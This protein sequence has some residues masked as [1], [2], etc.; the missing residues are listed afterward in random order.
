M[1]AHE[2]EI[3]VYP[4]HDKLHKVKDRS[5]ACGEFLDWLREEKHVL[6]HVY[7]KSLDMYYPLLQSNEKLLAEFFDID[8]DV[9][10]QEKRMMLD[11]LRKTNSGERRPEKRKD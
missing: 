11:M 4:E 8:M 9:L 5:Q 3:Q 2:I 1:A 7:D 6:L 10:E